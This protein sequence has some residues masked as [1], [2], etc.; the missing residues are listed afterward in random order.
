MFFNFNYISF[1]SMIRPSLEN[2]LG[3]VGIWGK[4]TDVETSL[5]KAGCLLA[6]EVVS[7]PCYSP[8]QLLSVFLTPGCC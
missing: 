3:I 2:M 8:K 5:E 1:E 6:Q 4:I 7:R